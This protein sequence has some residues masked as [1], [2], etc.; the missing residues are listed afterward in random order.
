ME[1]ELGEEKL[2]SIPDINKG[3]TLKFSEQL[4]FN[5]LRK[6]KYKAIT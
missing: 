4:T 5:S 1:T 2:I 3:A 6:L